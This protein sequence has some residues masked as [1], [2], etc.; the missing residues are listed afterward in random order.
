V[1]F[2]VRRLS[3]VAAVVASFVAVATPA[4]AALT[5]RAQWD[6]DSAPTMIDSAGG[7]NNG[8]ARDV[9]VSGG[10]YTFNGRSSYA[11]APDKANLD[12]GTAGV[13]LT[14]RLSIPKPPAVGQTFDILR[15]GT[16]TTKGGYYKIE[17]VRTSSGQAVANCR[18]KDGSGRSAQFRGAASLAGKGFVTITCTKTGSTVTVSAGGQTATFKKAVGSISNSAAVFLGS[19]GDGTDWF[20]GAMDFAKIEIG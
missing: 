8:T 13:R 14:A 6:M 17:I 12:P 16:A 10:A 2:E 7:D 18:F 19:K 4:Q 20:P 5:V 11:T 3:I 9:T 1:P 15:K